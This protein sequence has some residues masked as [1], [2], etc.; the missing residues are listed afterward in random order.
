MATIHNW[1]VHAF[2]YKYIPTHKQEIINF[3]CY[4]FYAIK[5]KLYN[6][7]TIENVCINDNSI[8]GKSFYHM[9]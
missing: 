1:Q 4:L 3:K 9:L 5:L 8:T 2:M 6:L 7:Y